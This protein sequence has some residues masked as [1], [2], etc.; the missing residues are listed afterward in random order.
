MQGRAQPLRGGRWVLVH[1]KR[2]VSTSSAVPSPVGCVVG[3]EATG[4]FSLVLLGDGA[5]SISVFSSS[6]GFGEYNKNLMGNGT[7]YTHALTIRVGNGI[8]G[9]GSVRPAEVSSR[10]T[11]PM[12]DSR[13]FEAALVN[14]PTAFLTSEA[15]VNFSRSGDHED[16]CLR[17]NQSRVNRHLVH[18]RNSRDL[19]INESGREL[20]RALRGLDDN[21]NT[22]VN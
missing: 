8:F 10:A 13:P 21:L 1:H 11:A 16:T 19:L 22:G 9:A 17:E 2:Q 7:K 18:S 15:P 4:D 12:M 5:S 14:K 6:A 20:D 3:L